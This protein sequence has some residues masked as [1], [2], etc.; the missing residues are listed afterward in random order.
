[1]DLVDVQEL[2]KARPLDESFEL[3][4]AEPVRAEFV[5]RVR[6]A[7]LEILFLSRARLSW[8]HDLIDATLAALETIRKRSH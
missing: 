8:N 5:E 4:L 1:M 2:I 6:A 3:E 7:R